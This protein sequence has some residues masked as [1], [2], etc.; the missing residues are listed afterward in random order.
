MAPSRAQPVRRAAASI[1][2]AAGDA[3]GRRDR[4][5]GRLLQ[6]RLEQ[7][8]LTLELLPEKRLALL[9]SAQRPESPPVRRRSARPVRPVHGAHSGHQDRHDVR[10]ALGPRQVAPSPQVRRLALGP[11]RRE[12]VQ[13]QGWRPR[14]VPVRRAAAAVRL[15]QPESQQEQVLLPMEP[16]DVRQRRPR[17]HQDR[18][19]VVPETAVA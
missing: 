10:Q 1:G 12:Q 19:R 4:Q 2:V 17:A 9:H 3:A 18:P 5:L 8:R 11:M 14:R 7:L 13:G 6:G 15:A 16:P